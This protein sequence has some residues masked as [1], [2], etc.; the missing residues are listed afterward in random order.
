MIPEKRNIHRLKIAN[1]RDIIMIKG[2]SPGLG[3]NLL[4]ILS[5]L[6]QI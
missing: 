6:E 3:G 2:S 4:K 5:L 1:P